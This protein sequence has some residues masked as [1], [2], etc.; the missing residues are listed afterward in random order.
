MWSVVSTA[1]SKMKDFLTSQ[2][3]TYTVKV[4]GLLSRKRCKVETLFLQTANKKLSTTY[5]TAAIPMT[6][7]DLQGHLP[8][9]SLSKS[10][11]SYSYAAVDKISSGI[12][13]RAVPLRH[14][15]A[16]PLDFFLC[17]V[18]RLV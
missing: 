17:I 1:M 5:R 12:A 16:E 4:R 14:S 9:A 11:F 10:D 7:S 18:C 3:V 6:L 13:R 15:I 8:I 2:E